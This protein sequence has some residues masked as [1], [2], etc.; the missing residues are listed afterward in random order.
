[1][2]TIDLEQLVSIGRKQGFL[3][4]EQVNEYLPDEANTAEKLD[5]LQDEAQ[6]H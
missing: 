4:Y 6:A 2:Q 5:Q 1:M 3:T